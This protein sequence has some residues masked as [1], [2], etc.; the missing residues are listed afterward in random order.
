MIKNPQNLNKKDLDQS[1][2]LWKNEV[3]IS[4]KYTK[5]LEY[6]NYLLILIQIN[7]G[8]FSKKDFNEAK[9]NMFMKRYLVKLTHHFG[10]DIQALEQHPDIHYILR[11]E[12]NF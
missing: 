6:A 8:E 10:D 1:K 9:D 4:F 5:L 2:L 11:D 7:E 12:Q 3:N